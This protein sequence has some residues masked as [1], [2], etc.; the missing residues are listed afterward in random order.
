MALSISNCAIKFYNKFCY[1]NKKLYHVMVLSVNSNY[2]VIK[3]YN[4]SWSFQLLHVAVSE[5]CRLSEFTLTE[6][7]PIT[8]FLFLF[9]VSF[10]A[11]RD[12]FFF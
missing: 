8:L 7:H 2:Y 3:F 11:R 1:N 6:P 9:F 4:R 5:P 12:H 10:I